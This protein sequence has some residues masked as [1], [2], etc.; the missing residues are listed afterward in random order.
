MPIQDSE[1]TESQKASRDQL[2]YQKSIEL[3]AYSIALLHESRDLCNYSRKLRAI[4]ELLAV[5]NAN[6]NAAR[7]RNSVRES[8][9]KVVSNSQIRFSIDIPLGRSE[10]NSN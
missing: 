4:N 7:K 10:Q 6:P 2:L 5:N 3:R 8:A 1:I 9:L